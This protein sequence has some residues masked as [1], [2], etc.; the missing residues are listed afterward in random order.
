MVVFLYAIQT[1]LKLFWATSVHK[2][3]L[4][5]GGPIALPSN[6][7]DLTPFNF[8]LWDFIKS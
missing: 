3:E 7:P 2:A 4:E 6:Y 1:D 8:F 5:E